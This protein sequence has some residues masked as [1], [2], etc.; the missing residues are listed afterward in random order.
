MNCEN[1]DEVD[2]DNSSIGSINTPNDDSAKIIL[3]GEFDNYF[4]VEEILQECLDSIEQIHEDDEIDE[5][6]RMLKFF[7]FLKGC[8]RMIKKTNCKRCIFWKRKNRTGKELWKIAR[9][10]VMKKKDNTT[11]DIKELRILV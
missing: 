4:E 3:S 6:S 7:G 9:T 8:M 1:N 11:I 10:L 5:N 2:F